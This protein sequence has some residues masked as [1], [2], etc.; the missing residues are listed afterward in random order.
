MTPSLLDCLRCKRPIYN[1]VTIET[2]LHGAR[3]RRIVST[4][5]VALLPATLDAQVA[6][7][8]PEVRQ[9]VTFLFQSGRSGDAAAVYER[10]LRPIYTDVPA[11]RTFRAYREAESPEPLDLVVVS[12]YNGMAGMDSANAALRKPSATGQ[13]AFALYGTL[14]TMTQTHHDQF[15]EMRP[16]M[17]D[18]ANSSATLTVFEYIRVSPGMH[19]EFE[20]RLRTLVRASERQAHLYDWAETGRV[21]VGDGWDYVRIFGIRSLADWHRYQRFAHGAVMQAQFARTVAARKTIIL[22]LD[23]KLS[24]R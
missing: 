21:L 7:S 2:R 11:L 24:V 14:G 4:L 1:G 22:R 5:C 3:I 10:Q 13:S 9:I 8:A 18:S 20:R 12:S 23:P 17:S 6:A 19:A 15:I 16:A